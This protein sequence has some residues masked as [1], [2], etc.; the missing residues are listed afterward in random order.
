MSHSE[1]FT[2][3]L[4]AWYDKYGRKHLPWQ[5]PRSPYAVW[6]SEVM[7]QQTQV[8]TVIPYFQRFIARFPT[9]QDLA[10]A[11]EDVVL[12]LWAGLGYY[13]RGR[14]LYRAAQAIMQDH[15]GIFPDTL[16][17]LCALPGIGVSTASAILS[18]AFE[19]PYP[20]LD[21]NVIRILSRYFQIEGIIESKNTQTLLWDYAKQC[22]PQKRCGDYTQAIMD[23]GALCCTSKSP[24][25]DS[26]PLNTTC[27]SYRNGEVLAYPKKRP[28][29]SRP[30]HKMRF[31]LYVCEDAIYLEKR[32]AKGI[33][34]GLWAP[35]VM[36]HSMAHPLPENAY[37]VCYIQHTFTHMHWDIQ[38]DI[39]PMLE[40]SAVGEGNWVHLHDLPHYGLPKPVQ[41]AVRQWST[42]VALSAPLQSRL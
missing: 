25:C 42:Q 26:C 36:A 34:G 13:S 11:S 9:V 24:G 4:L 35:P 32:P 40:M 5:S 14:N 38:V 30:T 3:P 1:R 10:A 19:K 8:Q 33:W 16:D 6:L 37:T 41:D 39:V 29:K 7:L 28:K 27:T 2:S 17:A 23:L 22:M 18:L 15:R 21:T 31:I 12:A 20:I